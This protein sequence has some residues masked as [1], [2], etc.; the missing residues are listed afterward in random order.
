VRGYSGVTRLVV[1]EASRVED[2]RYMALRPMVPMGYV[3]A[4][5]SI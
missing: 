2:Q 1:D 3:G 5:A 4:T